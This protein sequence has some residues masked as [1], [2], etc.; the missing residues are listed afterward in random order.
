MSSPEQEG[1]T[2]PSPSRWR[3]GG[4]PAKVL[5]FQIFLRGF[6]RNSERKRTVVVVSRTEAHGGRKTSSKAATRVFRIC[7][8]GC[9]WSDPLVGFEEEEERNRMVVVAR[10]Y[11][12]GRHR[13]TLKKVVGVG[14]ASFECAAFRSKLILVLKNSRRGTQWW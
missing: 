14:Y 10:R 4:A 13:K 3:N 2:V 5:G 8:Y 12:A 7:S 6:V 9:V 1:E 11:D